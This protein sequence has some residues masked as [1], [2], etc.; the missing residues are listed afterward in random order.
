MPAST[1]FFRRFFFLL[2]GLLFF[3]FWGFRVHP[4]ARFSRRYY[5]LIQLRIGYIASFI[6]FMLYL[7]NYIL[8]VCI[9][10]YILELDPHSRLQP[11]I[12]AYFYVGSTVFFE[13]VF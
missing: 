11:I 3:L 13:Y 7:F 8:S 12:T 2:F 5:R 9:T 4:V 1:P 10:V 6:Y